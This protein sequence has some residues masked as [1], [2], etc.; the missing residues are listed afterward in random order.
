[1]KKY[2]PVDF[3]EKGNAVLGNAKSNPTSNGFIPTAWAPG[4]GDEGKQ[5]LKSISIIPAIQTT[6]AIDTLYPVYYD[7]LTEEQKQSGYNAEVSGAIP[8]GDYVATF[9]PTEDWY[10]ESD[11][12]TGEKGKSVEVAFTIGNDQEPTLLNVVV[13]NELNTP[14]EKFFEVF[15]SITV[16]GK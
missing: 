13:M 14:P 16:N 15:V 1:M 5:G 12:E 9:T 4:G 8:A 6:P 11:D 7:D 10:I 3:D 2:Y